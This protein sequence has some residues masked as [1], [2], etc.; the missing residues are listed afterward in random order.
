M[1]RHLLLAILILLS[2]SLFGC[3]KSQLKLGLLPGVDTIEV[4]QEWVDAGVSAVYGYQALEF[5]VEHEIDIQT[6]GE[7]VVTYRVI[8]QEITYTL[9]RYVFVT[10][11]TPPQG[12]LNPGIDT[13]EVNQEWQDA[14]VTVTDNYSSVT[15][16]VVGF[17]DSNQIGSYQITYVLI[18]VSGNTSYLYRWVK[19]VGGSL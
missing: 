4:G 10:D 1:R 11:Q 12:S 7:Y 2:T 6:I 16:N 15:V 8:H 3:I 14:G 18:D 5:T 9:E 13:I 17:V 19:V